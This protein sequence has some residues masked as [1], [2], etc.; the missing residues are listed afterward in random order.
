MQRVEPDR[1]HRRARA[2]ATLRPDQ[3]QTLAEVLSDVVSKAAGLEL[4]LSL[5]IELEAEEE[6]PASRLHEL[7]KV[8]RKVSDQLQFPSPW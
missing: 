7:N 5:R 1:R 6:L 3:V 4:T 2:E 8:L